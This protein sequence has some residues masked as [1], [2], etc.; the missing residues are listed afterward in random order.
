MNGSP[1]RQP[2]SSSE[3][4]IS[5]LLRTSTQLPARSVME[6]FRQLSCTLREHAK[7]AASR[8][9]LIHWWRPRRAAIV[10][11]LP[12]GVTADYHECNQLERGLLF[13]AA[14]EVDRFTRLYGRRVMCMPL[15][16]REKRTS[17]TCWFRRK[18]ALVP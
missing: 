2:F 3:R 10:R 1:S 17:L 6:P 5:S 15:V 13:H 16:R 8:Q 11:R 7:A 14:V 18:R 12:P 4:R 9:G